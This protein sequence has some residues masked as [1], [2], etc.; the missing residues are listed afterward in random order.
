M[1]TEPRRHVGQSDLISA[2]GVKSVCVCVCELVSSSSD[3][4]WLSA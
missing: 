1:F 4:N 3:R 2:A